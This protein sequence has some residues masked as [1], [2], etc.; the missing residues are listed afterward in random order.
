MTCVCVYCKLCNLWRRAGARGSQKRVEVQVVMAA[1]CVVG[2]GNGTLVFCKNSTAD[3]A[4]PSSWCFL[5]GSLF[6]REECFM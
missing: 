4:Q 5:K 2:A 3:S 1:C 6:L